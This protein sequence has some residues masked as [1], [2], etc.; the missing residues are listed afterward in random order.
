M[1]LRQLPTELLLYIAK[2]LGRLRDVNSLV[3]TSRY[4]HHNLDLYLYERNMQQQ[5]SS[6]L[7]WAASR[8]R[9][10]IIQKML[11]FPGCDL[12]TKA[13]RSRGQTP[14]ITACRQG[15]LDVVKL[16]L[17]AT[18]HAGCPVHVD[19]NG[20]DD[21]NDTALAAAAR[22]NQVAIVELL[23][24]DERIDVNLGNHNGQTPLAQAAIAGSTEAAGLL[25]ATDSIK[26]DAPDNELWTPLMFASAEGHLG[27]AKLLLLQEGR[28]DI[29]AQDVNGMTPLMWAVKRRVGHMMEFLLGRD[30]L[31]LDRRNRSRQSAL[32]FAIEHGN[33]EIVTLLLKAGAYNPETWETDYDSPPILPMQDPQ[34]EAAELIRFYWDDMWSGMC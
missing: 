4:F 1:G 32:S 27:M 14:L 23:L 6:A 9:A 11:R 22:E 2:F 13:T 25:L 24:R 10:D 28:V 18:D 34:T 20:Q 17:S 33:L 31:D 5:N 21:D 7:L 26:P 3:L 15:H 8:G 16:L 30:D 12:E 29:N 19:V